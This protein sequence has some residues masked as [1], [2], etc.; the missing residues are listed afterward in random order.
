[1]TSTPSTNLK[2]EIMATGDQSGSWGTTTNNNLGTLLE[3]AIV[4][5]ATQV[6]TNGA[7]TVLTIPDYVSSTG[8]NFVIELTG[9]LS[10][11]RTVE[12]PAVDKPYIFFNNTSGGYAVTVKVAGQTGVSIANGKKALVYCN[13]V[14]VISVVNAAVTEA[15]AQT[16]TNK[17]IKSRITTIADAVSVTMNGDTTDI[18]QQANTQAVGTLTVNA[19]TGTPYDT[20]KLMFRLKSTNVQTF[21]WNAIFASSTDTVLPTASSGAGKYDYLGFIYNS[22]NSKWQILAK[23]MGFAA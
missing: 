23:N 18:A 6:V 14:D 9:A 1:M 20:Q 13:S 19:P 21:A 15:D 5:Y 2:L 10:S 3:Q 8:R 16:L 12:V 4:G 17:V 7:N 11:D 22:V